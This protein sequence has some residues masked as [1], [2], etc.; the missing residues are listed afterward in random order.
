LKNLLFLSLLVPSVSA[1][2]GGFVDQGTDL[3]HDP[4]THNRSYTKGRFENFRELY[5]DPEAFAASVKPVREFAVAEPELPPDGS[6]M[7]EWWTDVAALGAALAERSSELVYD[8]ETK[9]WS[10]VAISAPNEGEPAAEP[11]KDVDDEPSA[12]PPPIPVRESPPPASGDLVIE[13]TSTS[14]AELQINGDKVGVVGPLVVATIAGIPAGVYEVSF[15]V[16]N[17]FKFR[18]SI[19]TNPSE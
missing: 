17:G 19:S 3:A 1:F 14:W 15:K 11:A 6:P 10:V 7:T 2:A 12:A 13:N 18:K 4:Y 5:V 9:E 16:Q 8:A